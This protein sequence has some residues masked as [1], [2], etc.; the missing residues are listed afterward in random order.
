MKTILKTLAAVT[1][2]AVVASYAAQAADEPTPQSWGPGWR[3]EQ[4]IKAQADGTFIPGQG[5]GFGRG[6]MAAAIGPDGKI[7]P[8]KLPA[9]CP[10]R[11]SLAK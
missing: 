1:A 3:H 8:A 5:P 10:M 4:M 9:D 7:D 2:L 11:Q 6:R